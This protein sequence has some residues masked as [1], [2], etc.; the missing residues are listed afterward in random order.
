MDSIEST[1]TF[2]SPEGATPL[3]P[4]DI[5]GLIPTH[6]V[7]RQQ[8]NGLEQQNITQAE[9]W[10]MRARF[11][12]I[13]T[14]ANLRKLHTQM[15]S[16]VWKWAGTFRKTGKNIG[17]EAYQIAIELKKLCDDVDTWIK[18]SSYTLDELAVRFHHRLVFIHAFPN[19]NG[20][21]ARLATDIL[22]TKQLSQD[23]FTWGS[24]L[25]EEAGAIRQR[26]ISALQSADRGDFDP[27]LSF[28]KS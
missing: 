27:L 18:F 7:N 12:K 13:N 28:V 15:F 25:I 17:I 2:D 19:G 20:R 3:D 6:I 4:D 16:Q 10:L 5:D 26:Y 21:H 14:E 11:K 1:N 23:R 22:L 24:G 8:L 9:L